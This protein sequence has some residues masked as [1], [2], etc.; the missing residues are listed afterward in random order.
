MNEIDELLALNRAAHEAAQQ[1]GT[2]MTSAEL[3]AAGLTDEAIDVAV[4]AWF[5]DTERGLPRE[6]EPKAW[7]RSRM[8]K[9]FAAVARTEARP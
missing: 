1:E 3:K 2:V 9:A 5:A 7:L 6:M 8:R 4:E